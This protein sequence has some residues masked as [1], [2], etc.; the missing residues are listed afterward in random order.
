MIK[1]K[2]N[3]S[4]PRRSGGPTIIP[5]APCMQKKKKRSENKS[6]KNNTTNVNHPTMS[7]RH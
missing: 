2:Q 1:K 6:W 5:T 4:S 3:L 7:S